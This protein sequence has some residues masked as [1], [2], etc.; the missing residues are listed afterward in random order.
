MN[1]PFTITLKNDYAFKRVFGVE[2]NKAILQD[3]LECVLDIPSDDINTLELLNK[4]LGKDIL[5]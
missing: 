3:F 4:E 1:E 2:E 5:A